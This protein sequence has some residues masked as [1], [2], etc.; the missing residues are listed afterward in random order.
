MHAARALP[1]LLSLLW[2]APGLGGAAPRSGESLLAGEPPELVARL[3]EQKVVLL[4][5]VRARQPAAGDLFVAYVIFEQPPGRVFE[6]LAEPTRQ[7]EYRPELESIE[8]VARRPGEVVVEQ[9]MKVMFVPL[10]YRLRHRLD[11]GAARVSWD[12]DPTFENSFRIVEGFWELFELEGGRTLAR[13][14]SVVYVGPALP[15]SFQEVLTRRSV[16]RNVESCRRWVDSGG[17]WR[18]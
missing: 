13:F 17:T 6:L 12:L 3:R 7:R 2:L 1:L 4:Q 15:R 8:I 14:G 18:P 16:E 11:R 10:V 9:R 5:E